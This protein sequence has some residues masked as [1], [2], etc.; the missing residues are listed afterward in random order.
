[1]GYQLLQGDCRAV[2]SELP[3][4]SVHCIVTSPPY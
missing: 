4:K 1:M 2:L 3:E